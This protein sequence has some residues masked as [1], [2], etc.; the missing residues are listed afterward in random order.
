M[1]RLPA[2]DVFGSTPA[3]RRAGLAALSDEA[4]AEQLVRLALE[5]RSDPDAH[6]SIA[7]AASLPRGEVVASPFALRSV[8][9]A[10]EAG[11][12]AAHL[13]L[14]ARPDW[15]SALGVP[16]EVRDPDHGTWRRGVLKSGKYQGFLAD[17]AF[18]IY[19]PSHVSKWG[20]HEMMHRAASF[21]WRVGATRWEHYLG[22][23][24]NELVP[25]VLF[26]GPEQAMRLDEDAFDRAAAGL[27]PSARIEDARWL[28]EDVGEL[29]LRALRAARLVRAGVE[30]FEREL[31]A[32]DEEIVR[33]RRVRVPH[34]LLDASSDAT[35]YVVGHYDRLASVPVAVVLD[36]A[37]PDAL[38]VREIGEYRDHVE[39]L[40]DRLLFGPVELDLDRAAMRRSARSLWDLLHR[41]AHLGEGIEA[42]LEPWIDEARRAM[43]SAIE[44][45]ASVDVGM[46]RARLQEFLLEEDAR[47]VL[48][49]GVHGAAL[50]QL[51]E[52]LRSVVPCTLALLDE[53]A[54]DDLA[55]SAALWD[56]APLA[57][58]VAHWLDREDLRDMAR[59]EHAIATARRD[60][61]IERLTMEGDAAEGRV[62][63]SAAFERHRFE[64]DVVGVHAAYSAGEPVTAPERAPGTW[65]I[66][67]FG[68]EAV[69]LPCPDAVSRVWE[70][71]AF[72]ARDARW[73]AAEIDRALGQVPEGWPADGRAW[74]QELLAAG[75]LG[76]LE[77]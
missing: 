1:L 36:G 7:R 75:A 74:V 23:R 19:D 29:R 53:G 73:I 12:R 41:A 17:E 72:E 42:E 4:I 52:G 51:E 33:G 2:L 66:G 28:T 16:P 31:A 45:R 6:A 62:V 49:D 8:A 35:A 61:Q 76:R 56:R 58:R 50:E 20:P 57:V 26:Y 10:V 68:D 38:V 27:A 37:L 69:V 24:L 59:F 48:E 3:R 71:L 40:F 11:A 21:F 44:G 46:W 47:L 54:V 70:Q 18:A 13:E 22:A 9:L 32:I 14:R 55:H 30:H 77:P 63:S 64:H 60:D 43:T 67:G 39:R 15:P 5:L 34:P 65:L 25:V